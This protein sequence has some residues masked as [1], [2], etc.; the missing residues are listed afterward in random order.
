MGS[1]PNRFIL[2]SMSSAKCAPRIS[3]EEPL[4]PKVTL[5]HKAP[6]QRRPA[7]KPS[8]RTYCPWPPVTTSTRS[9][10]QSFTSSSIE[11]AWTCGET[12]NWWTLLSLVQKRQLLTRLDTLFTPQACRSSIPVSF[13]FGAAQI[14]S[15]ISATN[16]SS[17]SALA[18]RTVCWCPN[19]RGSLRLLKV[20]AIGLKNTAT[21]LYLLRLSFDF[22][23]QTLNMRPSCLFDCLDHS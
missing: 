17:I 23:A 14:W 11:I 12:K 6:G 9:R 7:T 1:Y 4:D 16:S 3:F 13:P 21:P 10:M 19:T 20:S 22:A 15:C 8:P 18:M 2:S 5:L